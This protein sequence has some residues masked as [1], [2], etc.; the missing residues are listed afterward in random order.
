MTMN[1]RINRLRN[2]SL[3]AQPSLSDERARLLTAFYQSGVART[4]PVPVQRAMAFAAIMDG[5]KIYIGPEELIV[6]ERGPAP[7]ATPTY[8][9]VCLHSHQDLRPDGLPGKGGLRGGRRFGSHAYRESIIPFWQGKSIR[10]TLFSHLPDE[11]I[12][13]YAAGIFTEFQEQRSPGHTAWGTRST[14]KGLQRT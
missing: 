8:P 3:A 12:A 14:G 6:G 10:E 2:R 7:K 4:A 5:K 11:W 1:Q 9:E 13:A